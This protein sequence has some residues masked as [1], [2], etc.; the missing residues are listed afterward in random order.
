MK[1]LK[2]LDF[3]GIHFHFYV[4]NKRKLYTSYG[5]IISIVCIFCCIGIFLI[6]CLK[7]L[8][9]KNPITNISSVSQ[10][11][12]HKI[13][14]GKEK[15]WIPWRIV[16]FNK[17]FINFTNLLYPQISVKKGEKNNMEEGFI[18]KTSFIKY[19]LCNESDFAR[20]GK[21]YYLD[22]PLNELYCSEIDSIELGGGWNADFLNYLEIDLYICKDGIEYNE[23]NKN[24]TSYEK[25]KSN[26]IK[27]NSWAFEYFYPIVEFQPTNYENPV[28]VIYKN[29]FYNFSNTLKKEER[30]YIQEY[31]LTDDKGLV[32]NDEINSS[33]WGYISSDF[34]LLY[35]SGEILNRKHSSKLYSLNIFLDS[36]KIL[37]TR[38][39]NKV[40]TIIAN[41]FP[42]FNSV[43]FIFDCLTFMVKTIMTEKYLSELF[44]QRVNEHEKVKVDSNK[45]KSA[46]FFSNKF[47]ITLNMSKKESRKQLNNNSIDDLK[48]IEKPNSKREDD[49]DEKEKNNNQ[50]IK[51]LNDINLKTIEEN[52]KGLNFETTSVENKEKVKN[53]M[54]NNSVEESKK[55][56]CSIK[57]KKPSKKNNENN[58]SKNSSNSNFNRNNLE[59][60]N[61]TLKKF[62]SNRKIPSINNSSFFCIDSPKVNNFVD[63]NNEKKSKFEDFTET[64]E[65]NNKTLNNEFTNVE[66]NNKNATNVG[67]EAEGDGYDKR[68]EYKN[69]S[70]YNFNKNKGLN[71]S[72]IITRF[73]LK[74]SLFSIKDYIY[75]FFVKAIRKEYKYLSKEFGIIFNFLSEIYDISSYLQ[76]YKQ[77]HILSGFLLDNIADIDLNHKI[78]I[79]DKDL[80]EQIALK[81]KNV[82]YFALKEQFINY[83]K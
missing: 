62:V 71:N 36:G 12:Y 11:G 20:R 73:R 33:F 37:Y 64:K 6:L 7:D 39:Y 13:K 58:N 16:D 75:S 49:D 35:S 46:G 25:L 82:F 68:E 50:N 53:I 10:A 81:N 77:F 83:D 26:Y 41:V 22:V 15:L 42:I 3:F 55:N 65:K 63:L 57:P 74:G 21:N 38:R 5:G 52:L 43:F 19:K 9:H 1:F 29:R 28:L 70:H 79:N 56:N 61:S 48:P 40:Y 31:V 17:N 76:L 59:K 69:F 51:F 60:V 4:G 47:R 24:C 34:D 44:F 18:F 8:L 78:N 67:G 23:N 80:F 45:R 2:Y 66:F 14:F 32:F 54:L 27:N 72:A 30:L